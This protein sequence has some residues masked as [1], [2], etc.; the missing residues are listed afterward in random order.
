MRQIAQLTKGHINRASPVVRAA[1][2]SAQ[3][4]IAD[5]KDASLANG[6]L[7]GLS[8]EE[9]V[10]RVSLSVPPAPADCIFGCWAGLNAAL[11]DAVGML[12]TGRTWRQRQKRRAALQLKS[13]ATQPE[14]IQPKVVQEQTWL[15]RYIQKLRM[16][17]KQSA[18]SHQLAPRPPPNFQ[19]AQTS[20]MR[21]L[22]PTRDLSPPN[23]P[24]RLAKYKDKAPLGSSHYDAIWAEK[25]R[26]KLEKERVL[27]SPDG[28]NRSSIRI[29]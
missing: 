21:D 25:M 22:E 1:Q 29:L 10:A 7:D 19:P 8:E 4:R 20:S 12:G 15:Q 2:I 24:T 17:A 26:M 3:H 18:R 27:L 11:E 16:G 14:G 6:G 13:E 5:R 9:L 28:K 23:S